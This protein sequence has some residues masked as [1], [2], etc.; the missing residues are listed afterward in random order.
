MDEIRS[1]SLSTLPRRLLLLA[2]MA[3][4]LS[5]ASC[6]VRWYMGNTLAEYLPGDGVADELEI[7]RM[8]LRLAPSDPATHLTLAALETRNLNAGELAAANLHYEEAV[9][10]SPRDYRLWI[11]LGLARERAGDA[12]RGE[13]ALRRGVE[14]APAFA[15]PRWFLGNLLLRA[16]RTDEAFNELREA[17][18]SDESLRAQTINLAWHVYGEDT[19]ALLKAVGDSSAARARLAAYLSGRGESVEAMRLWSDL[20][21]TEKQEQRETGEALMKSMLDAKQ[22][23]FALELERGLAGA[24]ANIP[25]IGEVRNAGF[26]SEVALGGAHPFEWHIKNPP[27]ARIEI[28]AAQKHSGGHSLRVVF[29]ARTYADFSQ[30]VPV[31]PATSYRF[32]CFVRTAELQSVS[33][34]LIE[35]VDETDGRVLAAS[36]PLP[37]GNHEWQPLSIF[38]FKTGPQ[39]QAVTIR[40]NREPCTAGAGCPILGTVW[41]DDFRLQRLS[42]SDGANR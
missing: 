22:Y 26:E 15:S 13:Q 2:A 28:D 38:N 25:N 36:A 24:D 18:Q 8:A 16:G 17:C 19:E 41:Y 42:P 32:E 31:E 6:A 7:A 39:T 33:L 29:N 27:Q 10:L 12:A 20:N 34:P 30:L 40:T 35:I 14:L 4:V 9:R 11:E 21:A 5:G 1:V 3:L 37:A 23:L